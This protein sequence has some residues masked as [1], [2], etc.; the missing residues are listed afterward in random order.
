LG[1]L[2]GLLITADMSFS[3]HMVERSGPIE[4]NPKRPHDGRTPNMDTIK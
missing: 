2:E 3:G 4:Y 1:G